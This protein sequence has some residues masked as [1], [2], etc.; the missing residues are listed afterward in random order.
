MARLH[1]PPPRPASRS[2]KAGTKPS[3]L[4]LYNH[5]RSPALPGSCW[6]IFLHFWLRY[7]TL[8]TWSLR[9]EPEQWPGGRVRP[10]TVQGLLPLPTIPVH[11]SHPRG[12]CGTPAELSESNPLYFEESALR[13]PPVFAPAPFLFPKMI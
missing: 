2:L 1:D 13:R 12:F 6:S 8:C 3:T 10:G 9:L 7:S 4:R 11:I 5:T